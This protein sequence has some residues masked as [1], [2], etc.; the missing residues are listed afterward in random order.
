MFLIINTTDNK[1]I[2]IILAQSEDFFELKNV[3]GE[4][5]Q[6]EKLLFGINN[7]LKQNKIKMNQLKGIGVV[8]G[9]GSFTALRIGVV[10]ANTL[11]H[12]L[13]VPVVG[14]NLKDFSSN[15]ELVNKIIN[16]LKQA[17]VGDI[18]LPEYGQSPNIGKK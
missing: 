4:R 9:S 3:K 5:Q 10:T 14:I 7:F 15:K 13:K 16:K 17:K 12:A 11:A 2:K 6:S 1:L 8:S 18:V